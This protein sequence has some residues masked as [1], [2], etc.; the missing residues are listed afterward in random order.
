MF[1]HW[2]TAVLLLLFLNTLPLHSAHILYFWL[3]SWRIAC[4][5]FSRIASKAPTTTC[6]SICTSSCAIYAPRW[7]STTPMSCLGLVPMLRSIRMPPRR[8]GS[9]RKR[10]KPVQGPDRTIAFAC[11]R[12]ESKIFCF[13]F[14]CA[15]LRFF[16]QS[17]SQRLVRFR[18]I[19]TV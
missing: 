13:L 17:G 16:Y 11:W 9:I 4:S 1:L 5:C 19:H 14:V 18:Y 7:A 8:T 15:T 12:L 2:Q 10:K 3:F 6:T